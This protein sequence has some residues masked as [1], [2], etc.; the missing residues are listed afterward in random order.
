MFNVVGTCHFHLTMFSASDFEARLVPLVGHGV[1]GCLLHN[2]RLRCYT[3]DPVDTVTRCVTLFFNLCRVHNSDEVPAPHPRLLHLVSPRLLPQSLR[4]PTL[5]ESKVSLPLDR[6]LSHSHHAIPF[7]VSH[8]EFW[9]FPVSPASGRQRAS[10]APS[11][12]VVTGAFRCV[13]LAVGSRTFPPAVAALVAVA[14]A[15]AR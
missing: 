11:L 4:L 3:R 13:R 14:L 15:L 2:I 1:P 7:P 12:P 8:P 10:K 6:L 5:G 9:P